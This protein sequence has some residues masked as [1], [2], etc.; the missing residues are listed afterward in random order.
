MSGDSASST[1]QDSAQRHL[2]VISLVL[3]VSPSASSACC[4]D[5]SQF[6]PSAL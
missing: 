4:R 2:T 3:S 1:R 6:R 5:L